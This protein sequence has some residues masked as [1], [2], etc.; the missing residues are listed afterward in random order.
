MKIFF[1]ISVVCATLYFF[2]KDFR[3]E[4]INIPNFADYISWFSYFI[5]IISLATGIILYIANL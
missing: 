5:G 4:Y 2:F 1:I 3:S